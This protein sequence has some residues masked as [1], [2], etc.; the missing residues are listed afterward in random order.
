MTGGLGWLLVAAVVPT[1]LGYAVLA[2]RWLYRRRED[3]RP[4]LPPKPIERLTADL[5][6]LHDL[7]DATEAAPNVPYKHVRC[8]AVRAAYVDVLVTACHRL[9]VPPPV[10]PVSWAEIYRV[11]SDLRRRGV[12][13]RSSG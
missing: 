7:V 4:P 1:A 6:R 2:A 5:R 13:V 12:D 8:R 11:E 9:E 10:Q 3:R